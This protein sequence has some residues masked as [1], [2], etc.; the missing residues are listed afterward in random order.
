MSCKTYVAE[1][2]SVGKPI[3]EYYTNDKDGLRQGFDYLQGKSVHIVP[4]KE[5]K[6]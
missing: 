5:K 2:V 1:Y 6:K 4:I 3:G